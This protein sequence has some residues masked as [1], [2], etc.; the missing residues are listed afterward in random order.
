MFGLAKKPYQNDWSAARRTADIKRSAKQRQR[1]L[2]RLIRLEEIVR[3]NQR[4]MACLEEF[5][6]QE[7]REE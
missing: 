6:P 1:I 7:E 4:R 2:D 5:I 3:Q